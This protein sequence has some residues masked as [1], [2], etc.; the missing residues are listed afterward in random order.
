VH[1]WELNLSY[2]VFLDWIALGWGVSTTDYKFFVHLLCN[3]GEEDTEWTAHTH[4]MR[5]VPP[6]HAP[7]HPL[8][9][10]VYILIRRRL[11]W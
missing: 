9:G 4:G 5:M 11:C 7:P 2:I 6:T 8:Y 1:N 10:C 3:G